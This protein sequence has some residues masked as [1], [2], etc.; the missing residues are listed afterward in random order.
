MSFSL[1]LLLSTLFGALLT[2]A[3]APFSFWFITFLS[4][5]SFI[6][7]LSNAQPKQGFK[8]GFAFGLGWFGAGVSWVHVSIADFGGVPLI[9]SLALM[10]LLSAYLALFPGL[11]F[12]L[13]SKYFNKTFWPI[14][15]PFI[16]LLVEWLRSWFLTG[17]PWLSLGYSQLQGPLAGW[18]PIIGEFGVSGL[19]V[20]I[21]AALA[22]WLAD[23]KWLPSA[24]IVTVLL[25]SGLVLNQYQWTKPT[26]ENV[27]I[28]MVQGN[29]EQAL[30]WTPEQDQ[31]T[32]NKYKN[33]TADHWNNDVVIWPEAAIPK[34]EPIAADFL[35]EIDSL[36]AQTNTGL[37]TGIVNYNFETREAFNNL[38]GL[39]QKQTDE[40]NNGSAVRGQ[41]HY[42]HGNRFAKHHLLPIG[43]FI[44]LED[45]IRGLAPIFDLP[46]S[47]FTR[48]DYQQA[49]IQAKGYQ[50]APAICF[51]IAFP[52]QISA[53]LYYNTDFIITVS[54]D[55]WFGGSHGPAQHL[56]IA[57]ARAK[58]FGLPVLR[59]TNTGITAFIDHRGQ[60]QSRL[61]QFEAAVLSDTIAQVKG[62]TPYR[63]FGDWTIWCLSFV[64]FAFACWYQRQSKES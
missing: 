15:L 4:L 27:R 49:N 12:Y 26:G 11:S 62:Y 36:A 2:L 28:A 7:L 64:I 19:V 35:N 40:Q 50:F 63:S 51:E 33:M 37:I 21:S 20:L 55:A 9:G 42:F 41:Y 13:L 43:E 24:L 23:K 58:E 29:I 48:G 18:F 54:N 39:G 59:A 61:P 45:W 22:I 8:L 16:W 10:L 6:Y 34:L 47:S 38:I 32:M 57:Q 17:F 30:R 5:S 14:A 3:Y 25:V 56:E 31:P 52:R 46:M 44:P 53:N 1:K 60:I